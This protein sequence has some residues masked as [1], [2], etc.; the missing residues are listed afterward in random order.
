MSSTTKTVTKAAGIMMAA[1]FMSRIL[2]LIREMV[3]ANQFGGGGQVSAYRMAFVLPDT[4]YFL[5]SSGALSS[6]FI[7]VFTEYWTKGKKEDAWQIFSVI[8]TFIFLVLGSAIL[9]CE[10]FAR[11]LVSIVAMGFAKE[12]PELLELTI[13]M[14]R[15]IL[16][17]QIFFFMGGLIIGTLQARQHFVAPGLGPIIYNIAI[18]CGG[19][20]LATAAG[21]TGLTWGALIGAFIGNFLLQLF[22]A[23]KLGIDFKPSLNLRHPGV[24]KVGKLALPVILGLS[25]PYVD[26]MVN[27]WFGA[28]LRP[29]DVAALGFANRLM[30]VPLGVFGQAAAVALLPTLA[31]LAAKNCTD[32]MRRNVSFGLRGIFLLTI[33]SSVL[34]AVLAT[35]I[36]TLLFQHGKFTPEEGA[37]ASSALLFYSIGISGWAAQAV[38]ARGFY[39][40]QDT[41][42]PVV[43]GTISTILFVPLNWLLVK[44]LGHNGL[45]LA[46]SIAAILNMILLTA[47]LR[48]R[49]GGVY[50]GLIVKS[51]IKVLASSSLAGAVAWFMLKQLSTYID[52]NRP[53][54]AGIGLIGATLPALIVYAS[55][56]AVLKVDEAAQIW[57]MITQKLRR[58]K[59]N[60]LENSNA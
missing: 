26:V 54:G 33:P 6:A 59:T 15:I 60:Y 40:I 12:H 46:T 13:K 56:I 58:S 47:W 41:V 42:A 52:I 11:P 22:V 29:G 21:I 53:L 39:A 35:P 1:I 27:Y 32:E 25:L 49:L 57:N 43:T 34:M 10:I 23:H 3:I 16:P 5:L 37:A 4:L 9:L 30:Q 14:T 7:P 48:H 18:I 51:L 31:A 36:V 17:S 44:P 55:L 28:F 20:F 45:A 50:G 38:V 24:V 2:G 8:G 19:L